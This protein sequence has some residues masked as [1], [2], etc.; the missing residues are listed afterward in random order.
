[1]RAATALLLAVGV[2]A[3]AGCSDDDAQGGSTTVETGPPTTTTESTDVATTSAPVTT[4]TPTT[5][6][7]TTST[8]ATT[9][10]PPTTTTAPIDEEALKAE[11][12]ED[13]ERAFYRSYRI[14]EHP[15][16]R[17]LEMRAAEVLAPGSPAFDV[18][19]AR[20]RELVALGDAVVPNDPDLLSAT[21]ENVELA[22]EPPYRRA[23]VTVCEVTN[24]RQVN[25]PENSPSGEAIEVAG[26]G[27]L[28]VTRFEEPV[29]LTRNGWLR[30]KTPREG[31]GYPGE[32]TCPPA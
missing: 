28:L 12:A 9:S 3:A 31:I 20:V 22:G 25:L 24:R 23:T 17:N 19:V 21:V 13:Y 18:F 10:A 5:D 7:P 11:I 30:Y 8:P 4:S 26:S 6:P 14:L 16:L 1:V 2:V 15:R 32:T 29:R 27:E